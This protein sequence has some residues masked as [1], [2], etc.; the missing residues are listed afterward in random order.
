M[1]VQK[2]L[3]WVL[4]CYVSLLSALLFAADEEES[5]TYNN[6][7]LLVDR[8]AQTG[9]LQA[10]ES[11]RFK[12]EDWINIL[13]NYRGESHIYLRGET[14]EVA[15]ETGKPELFS[16]FS[17]KIVV[18]MLITSIISALGALISLAYL[19]RVRDIDSMIF[20]FFNLFLFSHNALTFQSSYFGYI[21][22]YLTASFAVKILNRRYLT[23]HLLV[24]AVFVCAVAFAFFRNDI[25]I[26]KK[27]GLFNYLNV[28]L[29]ILLAIHNIK[30]KNKAL[31][32]VN[33]LLCCMI[34]SIQ[35]LTNY[36]LVVVG[37]FFYLPYIMIQS[38]LLISN[39]VINEIRA[40]E[41]EKKALA[42][43]AIVSQQKIEI[44]EKNKLLAESQAQLSAF[45]EQLEELVQA[46]TQDIQGLLNNV[47][48]GIFS[49][50]PNLIIDKDY[51][52][53]L[54]NIIGTEPKENTTI[55]QFFFDHLVASH[56]TV[57]LYRNTLM[58]SLGESEIGFLANKGN[59]PEQ[60]AFK[61]KV[62]KC[63]WSIVSNTEGL[64]EKVLLVLTDISQEI[65]HQRL[66]KQQEEYFSR[67]K[68][69]VDAKEDKS[70]AFFATSKVLMDKVLILINKPYLTMNDLDEIYVCYHTIKG[71][72]R[73]LGLT[74]I[75]NSIHDCES[76]ISQWR[77][78]H[79]G[80]SDPL[81]SLDTKALKQS[82]DM[83]L[84]DYNE[85]WNI[86]KEVLNRSD[87]YE[88]VKVHKKFVMDQYQVLEEV[89]RRITSQEFE[90]ETI[91]ASIFEH[92][93]RIINF[94]SV[95]LEKAFDDYK[96][97]AS[98]LALELKKYRP[99]FYFKIQDHYLDD[100][101]RQTLDR[102]FLHLIRNSID[103]GIESNSERL[104]AGKSDYGAL[105][106]EAKVIQ[107][108]GCL[109]IQFRDDGRGLAI[110][111]LRRLGIEKGILHSESS[112]EEVAHCI[113]LP[114]VSTAR[115]VSDISGRGVGMDAV[116][117]FLKE[118][119][120]DI[121]LILQQ[122]KDARGEYYDFSFH[123]ELPLESI[124][125]KPPGVGVVSAKAV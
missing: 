115:E 68:E 26:L 96:N 101:S 39:T 36:A 20:F 32:S 90:R 103:H 43:L 47:E 21:F 82:Y 98:K 48:L 15:N 73:T 45:N 100:S 34:A 112:P 102:V 46:K 106:V 123:I 95:S 23:A 50:G 44:L 84:K 6:S 92:K 78:E 33:L 77:Q 91:A 97:I 81:K 53:H 74:R 4:V 38:Y 40:L 94:I 18:V 64:V 83:A 11:L 57:D 58:C 107:E 25:E 111:H 63:G 110:G 118:R 9:Y 12:T 113:F 61:K 16:V 70:N 3:V 71:A 120:G 35:S 31:M 65:E 14:I 37:F 28:V 19:T 79:S 52:A 10:G 29:L 59:L 51:S 7:N 60:V 121:R 93:K 76:Q 89:Y 8:W 114:G 116:R 41:N 56:D 75:S 88:H 104:A 54:P 62:L 2:L 87:D 22:Y 119:G 55:D 109:H 124:S 30:Q 24:D 27:I 122:P 86:N 80:V 49:I 125:D 85:Y 117:R 67:I 72:S 66:F 69:L 13:R 108:T 42:N 105:F 1:F 99:I 17:S 5:A